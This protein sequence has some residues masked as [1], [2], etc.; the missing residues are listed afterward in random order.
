[1]K[2]EDYNKL[3]N[4]VEKETELNQEEKD[5]IQDMARENVDK[6]SNIGIDAIKEKYKLAKEIDEFGIDTLKMS[7]EKNHLLQRTIGQVAGECSNGKSV[8]DGIESLRIQMQCLDPEQLEEKKGG[9]L[10]RLFN[11][12]TTYFDKYKKVD[13]IIDNIIEALDT[14]K[15]NLKDDNTMIEIEAISLR[16]L[17]KRLNKEIELGITMDKQLEVDLSDMKL[18]GIDIQ[19]IEFIEEEVIFPLRQRVIDLQQM[20]VVN[21]Q[22]ILSLEVVR[23]N[24]NELIRGVDRAKYVTV[25]ALRIATTVASALHDQKVVINQINDLNTS[26]AKFIESTSKMLKCQSVEISRQA[27]ESTINLDTLKL[28]YKET[29]ETLEIMDNYKLE[30]LPKM[31]EVISEFE[32]LN[33]KN[34]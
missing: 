14:G 12:T 9:I 7:T 34:I 5:R 4:D 27:S 24:N 28:A 2:V 3:G 8:L 16:D 30:A 21:R 1:M 23:R 10:G 29:I 33:N 17:T 13:M 22:G 19:D 15:Q 18:R 26:T 25:S 11:Q 6:I 20:L 32:K 31:K